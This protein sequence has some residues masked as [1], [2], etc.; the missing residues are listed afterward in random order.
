LADRQTQDELYREVATQHRAV[1]ERWARAYEAD[2]ELRRDLLQE[3]HLA[4]WRS[5]ASFENRASLR[6]WVYRVAHNVATSHVLRRARRGGARWITLDEITEPAATDAS[7]EAVAGDQQALARLMALIHSLNP[8]DRQVMLLYLE[9]LDG[10]EI[11]E[12]TGL[13]PGAV[14]VKVHRLKAAL[15]RRLLAGGAG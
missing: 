2:R 14:A 4:V 6:T 5:L 9:D 10:A 1:L 11:S 15:A 7:P 12:I 3:I 8:A 13:S